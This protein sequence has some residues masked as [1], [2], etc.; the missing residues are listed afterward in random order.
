MLGKSS[1][2]SA[3]IQRAA[4]WGML[5]WEFSVVYLYCFWGLFCFVQ[6]WVA[7]F[8]VCKNQTMGQHDDIDGRLVPRG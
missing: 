6:V 7:T 1:I 3:S 2:Y 5:L 8:D 4:H